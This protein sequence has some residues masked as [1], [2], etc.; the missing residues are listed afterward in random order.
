MQNRNRIMS[1]KGRRSVVMQL[2]E[3]NFS[4]T[5]RRLPWKMFFLGLAICVII[6]GGKLSQEIVYASGV[7]EDGNP[8]V[9]ITPEMT[10]IP[11][12]VPT[13][14]EIGGTIITD[15]VPDDYFSDVATGFTSTV[16]KI[17]TSDEGMT[18]QMVRASSEILNKILFYLPYIGIGFFILGASIAMFSVKNKANRRWGIRMAVVT[19]VAMFFAY[20]L[21]VMLYDYS[22]KGLKAEEM[23]RPENLDYYGELYFD[24]YED[25]LDVERVAGIADK[26]LSKN[27][28]AVLMFFYVESAPHVGIAV[29]GL[30]IL[31]SIISKR[32][33]VIKKWA[34]VG[35]CV[36]VPL[37]LYLGYWYIVRM[38]SAVG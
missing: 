21:L 2:Q 13:P 34:G 37:I 28:I 14:A 27:I 11:T 31:L 10:T 9:S 1:W 32:N 24:V 35:L 38:I 3:N 17:I 15:G 18:G 29:F 5:K 16:D 25:I 8:T 26:T 6:A 36:V 19:S 4:C 20:I 12:A 23:V 30:G 33:V 7:Q 22:F